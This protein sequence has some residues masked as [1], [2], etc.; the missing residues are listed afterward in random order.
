MHWLVVGT[1]AVGSLMAVNLRRIGEHVSIKPRVTATPN[2]IE[3]IHAAHNLE[4]G[5]QQFPIEQP[6]Q[7]F[8]AI[9]AYDVAHFLDELQQA[10]LPEGSSVILSY[11]G[12]LENENSIMPASALHWVT[13]HGAYKNGKEVVHAGLGESWLGWARVEH[14]SSSRPAELFSVLNNA[15]PLLNWSP[16]INQ[17]RWYKLAINCL[18]NPF[19]VIHNCR[20]GELIQHNIADQQ[21]QVAEEICWLAEHQGIQLNADNLVES[22][23]RVIKNT[24]NNYSSML[25]DVRQQRRTEID[26]LNGFIARQSTAAGTEAPA[27][28]ALWRRVLEL[29]V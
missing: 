17:R 5:V 27:N 10:P 13:T 12:M 28:E 9:K 18:I 26:Y 3:I 2:T 8:A 25:M 11:N 21:H 15:L 23:K 29:S 14:A 20:N 7:I 6:T 24:A 19:T 16:A 1:G 22:A 4:F